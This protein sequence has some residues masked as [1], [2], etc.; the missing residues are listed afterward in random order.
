MLVK[1]LIGCIWLFYYYIL[2]FYVKC[3]HVCLYCFL[4]F[5]SIVTISTS[6]EFVFCMDLWKMINKLKLKLHPLG[7][8][9]INL[10]A[11]YLMATVLCSSGWHESKGI[12]QSVVE[13]DLYAL[14]LRLLSDLETVMSKQ[15]IW[16][17]CSSSVTCIFWEILLNSCIVLEMFVKSC[18]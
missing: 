4:H 16:L 3:L 17:F 15:L 12:M 7:G 18:L 9:V 5:Y 11:V 6:F 2:F 13:G 10:L 1:W 14:E 8:Y